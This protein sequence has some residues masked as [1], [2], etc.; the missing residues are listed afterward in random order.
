MPQCSQRQSLAC[1][2]VRTSTDFTR[3]M[4]QGPYDHQDE[5]GWLPKVLSRINTFWLCQPRQR[6]TWET[7]NP[8]G[9][10]AHV[11]EEE[12]NMNVFEK[13]NFCFLLGLVKKSNP[14]LTDEKRTK[15][16]FPTQCQRK[17]I[18]T[19]LVQCHLFTHPF[20]NP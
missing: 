11:F 4:S 2:L 20:I 13:I 1:V 3:S 6:T 8:T 15:P 16:F 10:Y 19:C 18:D 14:R 12:E 7:G 17:G 9:R 5:W